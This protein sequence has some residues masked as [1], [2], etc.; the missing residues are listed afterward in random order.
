[1]QGKLIYEFGPFRL[2]PSERLLLRADQPVNLSP[3]LFGLLLVFI[4]NAG[5]LLSKRELRDRVWGQAYVSEEALK[6]IV[7]NLRRVLG[8]GS[9]GTHWIENVRGGGYRFI[10]DVRKIE[11]SLEPCE[12]KT[13]ELTLSLENKRVPR[14]VQPDKGDSPAPDASA[15]EEIQQNHSDP[16]ATLAN[17]SIPGAVSDPV[18]PALLN[19]PRNAALGLAVLAIIITAVLA[20]RS[21]GPQLRVARYNQLTHDARNT[22]EQPIFTD[23]ARLYY[24]QKVPQGETLAAV[25]VGGSGTAIIPCQCTN[26]SVFDLSPSR[27]E[28]LL[29]KP[30]SDNAGALWV[31]PLLGGSPRRVGNLEANA[32]NWSRDG[33]RLAFSLG[34]KLFVANADGTEAREVATAPGQVQWVRWSPDN[35]IIRFTV[36][37][38]SNS[39][40]LESIWEMR[41]DGTNLHRLLAGWNGLGHECCGVWTPD[42]GFYIFESMHEGQ[43]N[44]WAVREKNFLFGQQDNSPVQLS[45]GLQGGYSSPVMS[46][47]GQQIFAIGNQRQGELVRFDSRVKEFVPFLGGISATWVVFSNS[48]KYVVYVAYPDKTVWRANADGSEKK[49]LTF[50]PLQADGL[51]WSPDDKWLALRAR[52]P[53]TPWLIYLVPAERGESQPQPLIPSKKEQGV[54]SWSSDGKTIAFGDVSEVFDTTNGTDSIHVIDVQSRRVTDIPGSRGLWTARW[55]RDGRFMAALTMV[56]QRL[57]LYDM[58]NKRWRQTEATN[59]NN[60][61]WSKDSQY[62]YFDTTGV[63][64]LRRIRVA[65][66]KVEFLADLSVYPYLGWWWSGLAPDNSPLVLRNLDSFNIYALTLERK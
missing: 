8:N 36:D 39:E 47:D 56:G 1:M 18:K 57:I 21:A 64:S 24:M 16:P 33:K 65:D 43:S 5:H 60:L 14:N 29:G 52:T 25:A 37:N 32:A 42:G 54:P 11:E 26:N 19:R 28:L 4:E 66:E 30:T 46:T 55:S 12:D 17:S 13:N 22:I 3:Q 9:N 48:G 40:M 7:G 51:D 31:M 20:A 50:S 62:I 41:P 44:L 23:G 15:S 10:A 59:V 2:N 34:S 61:T 49:Q 35:K 63:R 38:Y 53:D 45:S 58:K 6:V 27:S